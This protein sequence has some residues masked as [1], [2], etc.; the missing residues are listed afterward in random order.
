MPVPVNGKDADTVELQC[1]IDV[2]ADKSAVTY[3]VSW[4]H[5][6]KEIVEDDRFTINANNNTLQI[7]KPSNC[8][9]LHS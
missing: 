3:N 8:F 4:E 9:N 7:N 6:G 2:K 5:D 1:S